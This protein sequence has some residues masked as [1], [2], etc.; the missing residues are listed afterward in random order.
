M[1]EDKKLP[2]TK[3][4]EMGH[5]TDMQ[6]LEEKRILLFDKEMNDID[7]RTLDNIKIA[8]KE[9]SHLVKQNEKVYYYTMQ[10][11]ENYRSYTDIEIYNDIKEIAIRDMK[12]LIED[13]K[14]IGRIAKEIPDEEDRKKAIKEVEE[15]QKAWMKKKTI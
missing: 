13:L 12:Q 1:T 11:T 7:I 10:K 5:L 6:K 2:K 14:L 15:A 4:I 3:V 8:I 9:H